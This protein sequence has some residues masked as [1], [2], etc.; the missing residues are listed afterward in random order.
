LC[1]FL[2]FHKGRIFRRLIHLKEK[3]NKSKTRP[4]KKNLDWIM[5]IVFIRSFH[6]EKTNLKKLRTKEKLSDTPTVSA[7]CSALYKGSRYRRQSI[8]PKWERERKTT[9]KKA[10]NKAI[11][12]N[13]I[14][15]NKK[16][17]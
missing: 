2:V 9:T 16:K 5:N 10:N 13:D 1:G 6:W 14:K 15:T 4:N 7:C 8:V 3:S 17:K 11:K 12:G